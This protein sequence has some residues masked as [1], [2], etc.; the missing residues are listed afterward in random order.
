MKY[1]NG[2]VL[3]SMI[4]QAVNVL[5]AEEATTKPN[6]VFIM[7]DQQS[8]NMISAL[9]K[10]YNL[11]PNY[12][13][14]PNLDKLVNSGISFTNTYCANPLSVPS[15]FALFTGEYGGKYNIRTNTPTV[16]NAA[17]AALFQKSAMG[18]IFLKNG[19]QTYYG[20]KVHLPYPDKNSKFDPP[21]NY[22]FTT[23]VSDNERDTLA[24][25]A[26]DM[27]SKRTTTTPFLMVLSFLNPH[28]ICAEAGSNVS[29]VVP[30]DPLHPD[31]AADIVDIRKVISEY[32]SLYFYQNMAPALPVNFEKQANYPAPASGVFKKYPDYYWRKYRWIYSYM[33]SQVDASIGKVLN[34]INQSP[35]KDNTIIIFTSDHG[36]MQGAHHTTLKELPFEEC[37]RVPFIISGKGIVQNQVDNSLICNGMDLI[38]TMCELAG[39][40][41][42]DNLKGISLAKRATLNI[43]VAQRSFLYLEASAFSQIIQNSTYKYTKMDKTAP[44]EILIDLINDPGEMK[45][46]CTTNTTYINKT[47]DLRTLLANELSTGINPA[48]VSKFNI[49][50]NP[51]S[52]CI[53]IQGIEDFTNIKIYNILGR[54]MSNQ[55]SN[56]T[57]YEDGINLKFNNFSKGIYIVK[58][59]EFTGKFMIK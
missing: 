59:N 23:Y 31:I 35:L 20:G 58:T 36:E 22:G 46:V 38:P 1:K 25:V 55:I 53:I 40:P 14:T 49:F 54:D 51:A 21:K 8:Y 43:P 30:V 24:Q 17:L 44:N 9:S 41:I 7:T 39:I 2:I 29:T 16:D 12:A 37:Q 18:N 50:P 33:V 6:I 4:L 19:Y 26:A 47:N 15:R 56:Q 57:I 28:D 32:D 5:S 45:N 3:G 34:A 42:P 48:Y 52:D 13:S 11:N 10:Y 27:I